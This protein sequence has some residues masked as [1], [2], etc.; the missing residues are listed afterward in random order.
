MM[1]LGIVL[2]V[3]A[4]HTVMKSPLPWHDRQTS[5]WADL[6]AA[7]I[8]SFRMPVFFIV[9]GFFVLLLLRQRGA[10]G[11]LKNRLS[12]LG[13]P[14]ALLWPPLFLSSGA[15]ALLYLHLM[16]RGSWGMY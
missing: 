11:M 6:L 16:A 10:W 4:I 5:A 1:W 15:L 14:F 9:A 8:H 2:H 13:L 3:A 7:V 12:R